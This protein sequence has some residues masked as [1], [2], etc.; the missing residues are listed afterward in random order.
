MFFNPLIT[1]AKIVSKSKT[2]LLS[3]LNILIILNIF[4]NIAQVIDFKKRRGCAW[5]RFFSSHA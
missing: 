4:N 2:A 1:N 5:T 3:L